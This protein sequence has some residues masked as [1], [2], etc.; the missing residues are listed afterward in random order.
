MAYD[1]SG[2]R[3]NALD[4]LTEFSNQW[5]LF[6]SADEGYYHIQNR[7]TKN[8][9]TYA[10]KNARVKAESSDVSQAIPFRLVPGEPGKFLIQRADDTN[11]NLYVEDRKIMSGNEISEEVN[12][13]A[14]WILTMVDNTVKLPE[15]AS[16]GKLV[17]YHIQ[18][19]ENQGYLYKYNSGRNAGRVATGL[20]ESVEDTNYWFYFVKGSK[21]GKY[22]IYNYATGKSVSL[23]N[24]Y[25]YVTKDVDLP[26]EYSVSIAND[27][28]GLLI[29]SDEG[30][31]IV[32]GS[33]LR[34]NITTGSLFLLH[35]ISEVTAI[36]DIVPNQDDVDNVYYDLQ[37]RVVS[38]PTSG[39]YI[40]KGQ[41][42]VVK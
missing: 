38:N 35:R 30:N 11:V 9:I 17:V 40:Y 15:V 24:D 12:K 22:Q 13:N 21:E 6:P 1:D 28:E 3:A 23:S 5:Q 36:D 7:A 2:L 18:S 39:I 16:D 37:G 42:V 33:Y 32:A 41:K 14:W 29:S 19:V 26:T 25:L 34:T 20:L 8:F 27:C 10:G 4:P 31:W